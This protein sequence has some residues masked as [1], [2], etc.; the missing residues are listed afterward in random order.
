MSAS[1]SVDQPS[2]ASQSQT[3]QVPQ[4][5]HEPERR[6]TIKLLTYNIWFDYLCM[7]ERMHAIGV[8][9]DQHD[10]DIIAFQEVT[11]EN[12]RVFEKLSWFSRYQCQKPANELDYFTLT[13]TKRPI[14]RYSVQPLPKSMM[15]RDLR[16]TEVTMACGAVLVG[17]VHLEVSHREIPR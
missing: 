8:I 3:R 11:F 1:R 2:P 13:F 5:I 14:D 9:I 16:C 12:S 15:G 10:P 6:G 17:N 4:A 7:H